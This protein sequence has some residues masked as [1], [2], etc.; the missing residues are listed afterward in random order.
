MTD[1]KTAS[2]ETVSEETAQAETPQEEAVPEVE[3]AS[4]GRNS[5]A[6]KFSAGG[7]HAAEVGVSGGE[8]D[9]ACSYYPV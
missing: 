4:N 9:L 7:A 2:E 6:P 8:L 1:S 3:G 5:K